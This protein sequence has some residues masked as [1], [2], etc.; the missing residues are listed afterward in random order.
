MSAALELIAEIHHA[1]GELSLSSQGYLL[2]R[3]IPKTLRSRVSAS[4]Q[5]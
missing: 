4:P 1:G 5:P 2:G 3:R